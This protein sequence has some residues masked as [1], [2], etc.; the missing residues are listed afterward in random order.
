MWILNRRPRFHWS[1]GMEVKAE[2]WASLQCSLGE[3][4]CLRASEHNNGQNREGTFN[5]TGWN[6]W[7]WPTPQVRVTAA[8][9]S[10]GQGN[11]YESIHRCP[12]TV[13]TWSCCL[14]CF[15]WDL[16]QAPQVAF[17]KCINKQGVE[18]D[19][20]AEGGHVQVCFSL[21]LNTWVPSTWKWNKLSPDHVVLPSRVIG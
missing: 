4:R 16:T 20:G 19:L 3:H 17:C 15:Y 18:L 1:Q 13:R 8:L 6:G 2:P 12:W 14:L 10:L 9:P 7:S 5:N 21:I 11:E